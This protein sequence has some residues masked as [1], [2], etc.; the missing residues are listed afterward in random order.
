VSN[1]SANGYDHM[2]QLTTAT[3]SP[4]EGNL[5]NVVQVPTPW[6]S[7]VATAVGN[8]VSINVGRD[9]TNK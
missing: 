8:N 7:S 3:L 6:V 9:L 5:G 1:V 2:R 4:V